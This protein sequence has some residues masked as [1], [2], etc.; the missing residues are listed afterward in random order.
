MWSQIAEEMGI[1]CSIDPKSF[2]RLPLRR[3]RSKGDQQPD[4]RV[5]RNPKISKRLWP[6]DRD[7]RRPFPVPLGRLVNIPRK[8]G[9]SLG[10]RGFN[11]RNVY[12][13]DDSEVHVVHLF[14]TAC[15]H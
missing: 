2:R 8:S 9:K 12:I 13:T 4:G 14:M 5:A 7:S 10:N 6:R 3:A 15:G 1:P 11:T